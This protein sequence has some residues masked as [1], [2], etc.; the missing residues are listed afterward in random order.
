MDISNISTYL[1][2]YAQVVAMGFGVG[3]II[4]LLMYGI[5]KAL[6]LLNIQKS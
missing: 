6:G 1:E 4:E 5:V 3:A 2:I